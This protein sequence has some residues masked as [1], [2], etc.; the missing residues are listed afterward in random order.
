MVSTHETGEVRRGVDSGIARTQRGCRACSYSDESYRPSSAVKCVYAACVRV[1][2][3]THAYVCAHTRVHGCVCACLWCWGEVSVVCWVRLGGRGCGMATRSGLSYPWVHG[4]ARGICA[5]AYRSARRECSCARMARAP[6]HVCPEV[7]TGYPVQLSS[8]GED[9]QGEVDGVCPV[10]LMCAIGKAAEWARDGPERG[11]TVSTGRDW[12]CGP[13]IRPRM[14][15]WMLRAVGKGPFTDL[16]G[17]TVALA[18][19]A[20]TSGRC[21]RLANAAMRMRPLNVVLFARTKSCS[22]APP[23]L[24]ECPV[25]N[26]RWTPY[27]PLAEATPVCSSARL[28]AI[29]TVA[30]VLWLSD[31]EAC[32]PCRKDT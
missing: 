5:R 21:V 3:A 19:Q 2:R 17:C 29:T 7:R 12:Y 16:C 18:R 31:R 11:H 27:C 30:D 15:R 9:R 22:A 20:R 26:H 6:M 25:P 8:D 13:M 14:E 24:I 1:M 23:P 4:H 32:R 28:A 10:A